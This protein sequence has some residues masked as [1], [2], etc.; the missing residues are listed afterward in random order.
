MIHNFSAGPAILPK[1]AINEAIEGLKNFKNTGM[2]VVEI[3]HRSKA[4]EETMA[5]AEAIVRELFNVPDTYAVMFLQ[6]GASTQ[7]AQVPMNLLPQDGSAA[8]LDT[9]SWSSKAIKEA[10]LYGNVNVV[11]SSKDKNYNYI[12]KSF[13]VDSSNA[14]FHITTNNTIFGTQIH[15]IP[16]VSVPIVA[17]MSSDVFSRPIEIEKYGL[18]YA[19]AQKNMGPAGTTL[20]IV[21]KDLLNSA[22]RTMPVI[23][24]YATHAENGSMYNTP[25][26]FAIYLSYLTLKWVKNQGG[27]VEMERRNKEKAEILYNEI[28]NNP[29]FEGTTEKEDRSLMNATFVCKNEEHSA[30][31][32]KFAQEKGCDGLKGHRSVGGFRASIYNAL[33]KESIEHL[34]SV[35]KEFANKQ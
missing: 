34:V 13:E 14:Y 32:L 19:G 35:M 12:P 3:S 21:R 2:S 26:V 15:N 28:D 6:G 31:F 17:D 24:N 10:K 4:W 20:V 33:P 9:G 23:F 29:L 5:D 18:I 22:N 25:P 16:N 7:F 1:E 11:A 8:Y 27:L 30:D